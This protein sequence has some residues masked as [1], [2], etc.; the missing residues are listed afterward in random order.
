MTHFVNVTEHKKLFFLD[1]G[2]GTVESNMN[3]KGKLKLYAKRFFQ[4]I[5]DEEKEGGCFFSAYDIS[6]S[7]LPEV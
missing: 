3:F 7:Q 5:K 2:N 4:G 1:D 6:P